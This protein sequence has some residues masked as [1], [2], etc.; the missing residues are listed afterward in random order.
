MGNNAFLTHACV[1]TTIFLT[2]SNDVLSRISVT[3][4]S[5]LILNLNSYPDRHARQLEREE[6]INL[7]NLD[8]SNT[9]SSANSTANEW[10]ILLSSRFAVARRDHAMLRLLLFFIITVIRRSWYITHPSWTWILIREQ[11]G[12]SSRLS[13]DR[14]CRPLCSTT[15]SVL[16]FATATSITLATS[17]KIAFLSS[18]STSCV[19]FKLDTTDEMFKLNV[20]SDRGEA[21]LP[22]LTQ[23]YASEP[24]LSPIYCIDV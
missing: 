10:M 22:F 16:S 24:W 11:L 1:K 13:P 6:V 8:G 19:R 18:I 7:K 21:I 4:M 17:I 9:S 2:E 3:M 20:K 5:R 12:S 23:M 14:R 15:T